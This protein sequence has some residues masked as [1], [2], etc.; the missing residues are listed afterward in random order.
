[1]SP[2]TLVIVILALTAFAFHLGKRRSLGVATRAGGIR[3]LHSLPSYYG[4]LTALWC[5]VPSLV[6]LGVWIGFETTIITWL[7]VSDLPEELRSLPEE[8]L[9]LILNDIKNLVSG[10]IVAAEVD[11]TMTSGGGALREAPEHQHR[12]ARR[13]SR[14]RSRRPVWATAGASSARTCAPATTSSAR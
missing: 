7:V 14:S 9:G 1:M 4:T 8:R 6:L 3:K 10:N 5:G 12:G 13:W 2:L 11:A